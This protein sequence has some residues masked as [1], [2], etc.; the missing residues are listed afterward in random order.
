MNPP[1][2]DVEWLV[3]AGVAKRVETIRS[4]DD[5]YLD[6]QREKLL[7]IVKHNA[8]TEFGRAHRFGDIDSIEDFRSAVP[9][10]TPEDYYELWDRVV[11]GER[12]VLM[13]DPVYAFGLSSG[14]TGT[15]KLVPLTKSLVR[16]L[17]RAI[18][19]TVSSHIARS[20]NFSLLRG[21][22]LQ[23]A[24]GANVRKTEQGVSIGYVTGIIGA[25]RTYPFHNI[26]IPPV[27]VLD[28]PDWGEKFR[29]I[30][31]RYADSDVRM[32]FGVPAYILALLRRL[33]EHK[34]AD[35]LKSIWPELELIVTSGSAMSS[36]AAGFRA[37]CPGVELQE[38]Y[39][40]TEAAIAFQPDANEPGLMPMVED[41]YLEFVPEDRWG[42]ADAPRRSLG[43]V[44]TGVRYILLVTTPS[45]LYAYS[46]GDVVR[47]LS[48]DPPR[49]VAEGRQTSV[50][51]LATEKV[52]GPQ[53]VRALSEAGIAVEGFSVCPGP[54]M[55]SHEW[56]VEAAGGLPDDAAERIDAALQ[57]I[58]TNYHLVRGGEG[59]LGPPQVTDVGPGTFE[60]ALRR[61]AGQGKVLRIYQ[62]RTVRDELVAIG[63]K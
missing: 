52:N 4:L 21:Y 2:A 28:L 36:H 8:E 49:L 24:A 34:G 11:A 25:A 20:G 13:S 39:L 12:D 35:T 47:F 22:A 61:R 55:H 27:D 56:V 54:D 32:I 31:E 40:C 19:Y 48:V 5:T 9:A 50:L 37:L 62:D 7:S 16:G 57:E 58:N 30:I 44:E 14:T 60:S 43:E 59:I 42:E 18:G 17:K 53:A 1:M 29:I 63:G 33:T 51:N 10:T 38:M 23:M 41:V 45:G 26:G 15:P 6:L 46:P 3:E